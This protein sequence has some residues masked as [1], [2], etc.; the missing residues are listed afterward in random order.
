[1]NRSLIALLIVF[2][3]LALIFNWA[4]PLFENSDEFFHFPFI[5]HLADNGL[6]LPVQSGDNLQDWRQEGS[7]PPLYH[8][9]AAVMISPFDTDDYPQVHRINPHAQIGVVGESNINHV[10]HPLDRSQEFQGGTALAVRLVRL[11]STVLAG[12]VVAATYFLARAAFPDVPQ[13][14]ALLAASLVAFNPMLLF[15]ASS[16][17]NDNL[18]NAIIAAVLAILARQFRRDDL[19]RPRI[20]LLVGLLLGMG[21]LSKLSTGPFLLIVGWLWLGLARKHRNFSYMFKWGLA[22]L[23]V[24]LLVSAWWY[25]RNQ[26]LYGDPTGLN[27]FLDIVGRRPIDLTAEQLWSEREG[28]V[29]SF[30]GLYGGLTVDMATW[31]YVIFNAFAGLSLLGFAAFISKRWRTIDYPKSALLVW[32]VLSFIFLVRWTSLTWAS[33]GRLWFV[34]LPALAIIGALGFYELARLLRFE[35]LAWSPAVFALGIAIAAPFVWIR[36]AYAP[37]ELIPAD[38]YA[39]IATF[40]DPDQPGASIS[41]VAVDFP[42][43]IQA[44]TPANAQFRFCTDG[45]P[46]RDWSVFVHLVNEWDI[47]LAQAD[48]TPGAGAL[49]TSEMPPNRCWS[50]AYAIDIPPGIASSDTDL[51]LLVGL[52]EAQSGQRMRVSED[53]TRFVAQSTRLIIGDALQQ[54]A[55]ADAVRLR[56]YRL[57]D[58]VVSPGDDLT[59]MLDW[60]SI[61][62]LADDYTIFVQVIDPRTAQKAAA[63]DQ[64][65]ETSAW[66][67]GTQIEDIHTMMIAEDAPAGVY[68]LVV[69]FY[70]QTASGEF[71][72]LR[73]VYDGVDTGFDSMTLTQVRVE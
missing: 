50:D 28:F 62:P 9:A 41:L 61:A 47:I 29:R 37:P 22:S 70:Q 6:S 44:G 27:V 3:A 69:G 64:M 4:S 7:Q 56:D 65:T 49:P 72:R 38:E 68:A 5:R 73:L 2:A 1:M 13:W 60:E 26:D 14:V 71:E 63:S 33:Q 24:M 31:T 21:M 45:T 10:L 54:F 53:E 51:D 19:P 55:F 17:N 57:S 34:A 18:A 39:A 36:P 46:T 43:E 67:V 35:M 52:Y 30:W 20:L 15:V 12:V 8:M 42:P 25:I 48:F 66:T 58:A 23:A 11:F 16:I 59:V 40:S 32:A